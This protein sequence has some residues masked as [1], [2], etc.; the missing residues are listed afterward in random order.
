[1]CF[2]VRMMICRLFIGLGFSFGIPGFEERTFI[3]LF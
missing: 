3:G 2:F 1:M